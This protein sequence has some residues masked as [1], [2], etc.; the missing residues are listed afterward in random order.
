MSAL[1]GKWLALLCL[2]PF[3]VF[4]FAFQVAPLLW[5]A[6]NSLYAGGCKQEGQGYGT[7]LVTTDQRLVDRKSVV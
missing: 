6:I 2:L 5:V 4:F 3:A 7:D 1:R